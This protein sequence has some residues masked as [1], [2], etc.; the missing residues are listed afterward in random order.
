[1]ES[2]SV[3][4]VLLRY[5]VYAIGKFLYRVL[6]FGSIKTAC[7]EAKKK[8]YPFKNFINGIMI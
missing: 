3:F 1:M 2:T 8:M 7:F 4:E 6:L 5:K